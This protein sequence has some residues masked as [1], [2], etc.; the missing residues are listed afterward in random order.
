MAEQDPKKITDGTPERDEA[1]PGENIRR[2]FHDFIDLRIGSDRAGAVASI[3]GGKQM[4]GSNAWMLVCSILIASLGL[5]LNSGAVIIGA[6][7]IS[8]LMNPILG[9][10]LGVG[11]NDWPLLWQA[12]KNF[13]IAMAI[14]LT[15][16]VLYFLLTPIETFT[17]EMQARTE[18]TILDAL[19]AVFG[20]LAGI[21][22]VTRE[23][24]TNAIPGVAIATALMPP[25][26]VAGFGLSLLVSD[27]EQGISVFWRAFYLFFINSFFIAVTAY[28][29][30]RLLRFPYRKY[31]SKKE[32][33]RSMYIV[34]AISILMTIPSVYILNDVLRRLREEEAA[35]QF[36]QDYFPSS[37]SSYLLDRDDK[38][39]P[40]LIYPIKNRLLSADSLD[41][42]TSIL[43]NSPYN[44][45]NARIVA[46]TSLSASAMAGIQSKLSAMTNYNVRLTG[47]EYRLQALAQQVTSENALPN[48][49]RDSALHA[50]TLEQLQIAFPEVDA[51]GL[52]AMR[53]A[54]DSLGYV[55]EVPL[56]LVNVVRQGQ[57]PAPIVI[58]AEQ[59]QMTRFL[60]SALNQ[61]TVIVIVQER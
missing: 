22:S 8:P 51:L 5:N 55:G 19:V 34:L 6:M 29:I 43:Q 2:W 35:R 40:V 4:R 1:T 33:R 25:L 56:A 18:P 60:T 46:D 58:A 20:G 10:G 38:K 59:L 31:M 42:Y 32:A 27:W 3:E 24:K 30:I 26:C 41:Q 45:K 53:M 12:L 23:D 11:T 37:S 52:S 44:L 49:L 28:I 21:I 14:A 17:P 48:A 50:R 13:G 47:I 16:S 57:R 39:A 36:T 54:Q 9:I 15:T 7:L 61:D